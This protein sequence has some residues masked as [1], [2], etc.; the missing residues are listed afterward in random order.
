M[1]RWL[2]SL[3]ICFC[4]LIPGKAQ[5]W[6]WWWFY[7]WS[8]CKAHLDSG[9]R[10]DCPAPED[11]LKAHEALM[12]TSLSIGAPE[13]QATT[14]DEEFFDALSGEMQDQLTGG[15]GLPWLQR[16]S[17]GEG[18][19]HDVNTLTR[20]L[21]HYYSPLAADASSG[22]YSWAAVLEFPFWGS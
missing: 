4:L 7:P 18:V 14:D 9:D 17:G 15:G 2:G 21:T 10:D 1:A 22:R 8:W 16:L 6:E 19:C 11:F 13:D 20:E 12:E 5:A 3:F